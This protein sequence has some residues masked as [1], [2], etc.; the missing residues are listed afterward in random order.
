MAGVDKDELPHVTTLL[1]FDYDMSQWHITRISH[2]SSCKCHAQ[3]A[4]TKVT[5]TPWIAKASKSTPVPT[6]W[7]RKNQYGGNKE[8]V[9]DF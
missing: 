7:D 8:I 9:M 5:C 2:R 6:N 4:T 1:E 3:Q